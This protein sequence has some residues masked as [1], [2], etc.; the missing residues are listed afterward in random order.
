[1]GTPRRRGDLQ[2]VTAEFILCNEAGD[3]VQAGKSTVL[4]AKGVTP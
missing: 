2:F 3:E 1:M 4:I